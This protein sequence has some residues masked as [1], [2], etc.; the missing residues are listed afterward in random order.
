VVRGLLGGGDSKIMAKVIRIDPGG[1]TAEEE[2][3]LSI[4]HA[5]E[6]AAYL[7]ARGEPPGCAWCVGLDGEEEEGTANTLGS[8]V[9]D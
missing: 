6:R 2:V 7:A 8:K 1:S 5:K 9:G 4:G 3:G